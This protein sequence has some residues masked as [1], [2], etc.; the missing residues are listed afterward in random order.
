MTPES[1]PE[2]RPFGQ[3]DGMLT[4]GRGQL[5]SSRNSGVKSSRSQVVGLREK[6]RNIYA[7]AAELETMFPGRKFNP[8][9]NMVGSIGE[10]IAEVEYRVELFALC[11]PGIDGAVC[12]RNV[13]IKTTQGREV[14]VKKPKAADLLLVIRISSDG[15]WERVYDGDSERVWN[16][17][18]TQKESF[19]REKTISVKRLRQLQAG[20]ED[21]DRILPI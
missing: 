6:I 7:I 17:L 9:G 15:N 13:Q 20:V 11:T 4:S 16:A 1:S 19:M 18:A 5:S 12:G 21:R 3:A 14:A 10:A 8:D 2:I